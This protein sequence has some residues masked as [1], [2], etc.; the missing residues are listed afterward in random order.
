MESKV[1]AELA[2]CLFTTLW[3]KFCLLIHIRGMHQAEAL[4]G[5]LCLQTH[6]LACAGKTDL[7]IHY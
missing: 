7:Y 6:H 2:R 4:G 3:V 5:F 1:Q